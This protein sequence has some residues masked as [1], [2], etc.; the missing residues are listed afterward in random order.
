MFQHAPQLEL[1]YPRYLVAL[2]GFEEADVAHQLVQGEDDHQQ[3]DDAQDNQGSGGHKI[4]GRFQ[5]TIPSAFCFFS[6]TRL[7]WV[8]NAFYYFR[9]VYL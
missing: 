2:A 4:G 5:T 6:I 7:P 8:I 3:K 9:L 1:F